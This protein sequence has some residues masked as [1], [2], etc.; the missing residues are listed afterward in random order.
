MPNPYH[1]KI[2]RFTTKSGNSAAKEHAAAT[3]RAYGAQKKSSDA[4]KFITV[5]HGTTAEAANK[6][7]TDGLKAP[8]G[9]GPNWLML[10]TSKDQAQGYAETKAGNVV[11]EFRVPK[12][13]IYQRGNADALL[14]TPT[15]HSVY[16][17]DATAF[18]LRKPVP[19]KYIVR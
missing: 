4:S 12:T 14:W 11:I 6:I 2:G 8:A 7:R 3:L 10:T 1:D 19:A 18:A 5:Y 13:A 16:G 9:T 17:V 15:D